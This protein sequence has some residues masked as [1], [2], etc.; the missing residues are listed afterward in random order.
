MLVSQTCFILVMQSLRNL[1]AACSWPVIIHEIALDRDP[2]QS[3]LQ[4]LTRYTQK[5]PTKLSSL[6]KAV[7]FTI[8]W[9][10]FMWPDILV[11]YDLAQRTRYIFHMHG[12]A[13]GMAFLHAP[14]NVHTESFLLPRQNTPWEDKL[15]DDLIVVTVAWNK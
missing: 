4:E 7:S 10:S 3:V 12:N 8:N 5:V 13:K 11:N 15:Q 2:E 1:G 6:E 9:S 14:L